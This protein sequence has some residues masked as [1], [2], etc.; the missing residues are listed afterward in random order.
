M[1]CGAMV[2]NGPTAR[3]TR[4]TNSRAPAR[5]GCA[6]KRTR[7]GPCRRSALPVRHGRNSVW[8]T[9]SGKGQAHLTSIE[10]STLML[11]RHHELAQRY[12]IVAERRAIEQ[13]QPAH[14]RRV[15]HAGGK[16][17]LAGRQARR[18][19]QLDHVLDDVAWLP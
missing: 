10:R 2:W 13:G 9:G 19:L 8:Q 5:P 14:C 15:V 17:V 4:R 3:S 16:G 18:D 1:T 7:V 12:P 11:T 6:G